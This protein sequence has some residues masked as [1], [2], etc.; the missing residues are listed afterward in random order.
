MP[1]TVLKPETAARYQV[2]AAEL[3]SLAHKASNDMERETFLTRAT[4][5][6]QMATWQPPKLRAQ[7]A[8]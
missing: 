4:A 3:R 7:Y 5:Y 6:E 2:R 8:H 1:T